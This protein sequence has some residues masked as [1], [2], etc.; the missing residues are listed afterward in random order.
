MCA[1]YVGGVTFFQR[2]PHFRC[3]NQFS[4]QHAQ[5]IGRVH[6]FTAA[7]LYLLPWDH[8]E[9]TGLLS[10]EKT[11]PYVWK[12]QEYK[13]VQWFKVI[14]LMLYNKCPYTE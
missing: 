7:L 4:M 8:Y 5:N 13:K 10:C 11:T 2:P 6:D 14:M 1:V 12:K 3:I 9:V